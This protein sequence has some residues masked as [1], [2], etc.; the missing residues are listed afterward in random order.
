MKQTT[1]QI[2]LL[3]ILIAVLCGQL[4]F[5]QLAQNKII[6][7]EKLTELLE[8]RLNLIAK[9]QLQNVLP[10]KFLT[11]PMRR[12][13]KPWNALNPY[14][15]KLVHKSFLRHQTIK[16]ELDN[17]LL[18]VKHKRYWFVSKDGFNPLLY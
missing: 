7:P 12:H 13:L 4:V 15:Q 2:L 8:K 11:V 1:D 3:P 5:G 16:L 6:V 9:M 18:S 14:F 10:Y 17:M